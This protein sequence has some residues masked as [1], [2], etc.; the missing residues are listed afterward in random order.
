MKKTVLVTS[1]G[2]K[3]P[4]IRAMQK[5]VHETLP[6]FCVLA[7]DSDANA[8]TQYVADNF[9][10]MP[11][12]CDEF[13]IDIISG[14]KE[15]NIA[16]VLPTRDGELMF[17]ARHAKRLEREGTKVII[18]EPKYLK[19]CLDK[20]EFARFGVASGLPFIFASDHLEDISNDCFVVKERFGAGSRSIGLR[21]DRAAAIVHAQRLKNPIFQPHVEGLE[22]SVDAWLDQKRLVKGLVLRRRDCLVDGESLVTTTFSDNRLEDQLKAVLQSLQLSGPVV[23]QGFVSVDGSLQVIECN[24]RFGGASTI[25]IEAGLTSLHWSL[26]ESTG[27]DLESWPFRRIPFQIRQIRLLNDIYVAD[28]HL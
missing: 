12:T 2:R 24:A 23:L 1:S 4:L 21:L 15:R 19:R 9:W 5:A 7:G 10:V 28:P 26:L 6:S 27:A 22:I 18:S 16:I 17:W 14:L 20:L 13:L 11:P 3:A 8:L 25:G